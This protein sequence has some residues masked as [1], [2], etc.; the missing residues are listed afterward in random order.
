[1]S[2][3]GRVAEL[4]DDPGLRDIDRLSQRYLGRPYPTRDEPRVSAWIEVERWQAWRPGN[5]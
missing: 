1:V 2:L 4:V 5:L 3:Q